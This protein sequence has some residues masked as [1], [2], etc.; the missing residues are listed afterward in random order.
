MEQF[1]NELAEIFDVDTVKESDILEDF[2]EF[3]SLSILSIIHLLG[4]KY[5]TSVR[6]ENIRNCKNVHDLYMLAMGTK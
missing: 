2:D 5:H 3:D 6:S 4:S 1:L